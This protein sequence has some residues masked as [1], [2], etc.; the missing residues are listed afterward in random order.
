MWNWLKP[1]TCQLTELLKQ[2]PEN[3]IIYE[4]GQ[5]IPF[6]LWHCTLMTGAQH[7]VG[8]SKMSAFV[9]E[10]DTLE[11]ALRD[12]IALANDNIKLNKVETDP[13]IQTDLDD[14]TEDIKV[15]IKEGYDL[16]KVVFDNSK[17]GI[18]ERLLSLLTITAN[19]EIGNKFG[20]IVDE[21]QLGVLT[22]ID[23]SGKYSS[24]SRDLFI[25]GHKV[26]FEDGLSTNGKFVEYYKEIGGSFYQDR[27]NL[28]IAY[29]DN[30]TVLGMYK[31]VAEPKITDLP[32]VS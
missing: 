9:E 1:K 16:N 8:L 29:N 13:I 24:E 30:G 12:A 5:C 18:T 4:M 31:N 19:D 26:S 7:P 11:E 28:I 22:E 10:R 21:S 27:E 17:D 20:F 25:F 2:I 3:W 15:L 6:H 23:R 14:S 32:E